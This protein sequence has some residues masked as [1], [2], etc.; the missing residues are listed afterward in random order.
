MPGLTRSEILTVVNRY[1]GVT[2]GYLGDF[3]YRT[4]SEFYDEFCGVDINPY[5]YE[6]T[7]RDRFIKI[8]TRS[9]PFIQ[10][11]ILRG[12][13][14]KYPIGSSG[15]RTEARGSEIEGLIDRLEAGGGV[16]TSS[17]AVSSD[18]VNRAIADAETLLRNTGAPSGIDRMHTAFHGFLKVL[19]DK[20]QIVYG[21]DPSVT[22]LY[23]LLR[24]KH[25]KL[26]DPDSHSDDVDKILKSFASAVDSL[27]TLRNKASVAHPNDA[28]LP[29]V[30]AYLYI[31]AVKTL[32]TYL[33]AKLS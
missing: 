33:D 5:E 32:M 18:V 20:S 26:N 22:E 29:T 17:L 2:G 11:K 4:H 16:L 23:K 24:Q 31:N 10:A 1:I 6:G 14:K 13:I 12:V 25:P 15:M 21:S 27:N 28:L 8:L 3:S 19:C 7:T 30:E 9:E